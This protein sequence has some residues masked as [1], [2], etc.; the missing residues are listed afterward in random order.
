M[1]E[2]ICSET[3]RSC[4]RVCCSDSSWRETDRRRDRFGFNDIHLDLLLRY[5]YDQPP[6]NYNY[7]KGYYSTSK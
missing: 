5:K 2:E 6:F 4:P 3:L 7:T 1:V